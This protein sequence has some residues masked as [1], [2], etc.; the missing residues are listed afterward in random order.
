MKSFEVF[1]PEGEVFLDRAT[2]ARVRRL[3]NWRGH[4]NH[5]YFTDNGWFAGDS[6]ML[7]ISDRG[8]ARNIFSIHIESGEI[9]RLTDFA[10]VESVPAERDDIYCSMHIN[11]KRGEVYF[12]RGG[13]VFA[14][15]LESLETRQIF[16]IPEGFRFHGTRPLA[17]G[18]Y[19]VGVLS[20]DIS[21]RVAQNLSAGYVGM[22][23]TFEARH[24][25][26]ILRINVDSGQADAI[27]QEN[28]WL[29]HINPSPTR[30][31]LLTFCHEGPWDLVDNRIWLLD[32]TTG[33]AAKIRPRKEPGEQIGHEYWFADGEHIG[34]QCHDPKSEDNSGNS[35][36]GYVKYDGSGEIEA[37]CKY[38]RNTPDHLHSND[39]KIFVSDTGKSI[40][41]FRQENGKFIGPRPICMHDGS[42]FWGAHHPHP[43]LSPDG[44]HVIFNSTA[45]G[46]CNIY[47]VEIMGG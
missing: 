22:R 8:N 26:K 20:E 28:A 38:P 24:E 41:I 46:Y 5:P 32:L 27:W 35:W 29:G 13:G 16:A 3:T 45:A 43:R 9:H 37:D 1:A 47:M 14:L 19:I 39:D 21:R 25:H 12:K 36:F 2:G 30:P 42:F 10:A 31:D 44:R 17:C 11:Q 7:F 23:E 15:D 33:K 34:Y 4:S 18:N 40:N 6:R